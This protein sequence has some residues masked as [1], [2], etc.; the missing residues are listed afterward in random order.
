MIP[1][2]P[3]GGYKIEQVTVKFRG[4][5]GFHNFIPVRSVL[6][7]MPRGRTVTLDFTGH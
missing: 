7:N 1:R 5:L 4:A 2:G 3:R 6:D